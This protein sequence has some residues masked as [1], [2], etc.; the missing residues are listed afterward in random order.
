MFLGD[1]V[2]SLPESYPASDEGE[3][4][5]MNFGALG[6]G[7]LTVRGEMFK[8]PMVLSLCPRCDISL[9]PMEISTPV[10]AKVR[11]TSV[12]HVV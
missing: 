7:T 2:E 8:D 4:I 9:D 3:G 10:E 11:L 6:S 5:L 12:A 1:G